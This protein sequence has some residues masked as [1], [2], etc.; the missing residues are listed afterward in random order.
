MERSELNIIFYDT[1]TTGLRP[2]KDRIIEIAAYNSRTEESFVQF[3][4]PGIPIPAESIAIS[5][6]TDAMVAEAGSFAEV[7]AQFIQFCGEEA[8]LIA[9]NNDAFDQPFIEQEARLSGLTLPSWRYI[10]SLKWAR[11][12]RPDLPKHSLQA[13]RELFGIPANQ[14]HRALDDVKV[15]HEMFSMLTDDLSAQ[16]IL[17]LMNAAPRGIVRMP[18]GK[19][20]GKPLTEVP[21]D[22]VQWLE[23]NGAFD[24]SENL[25]LKEAFRKVGVLA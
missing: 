23:K 15:L 25:S 1:E 3:V 22:Y 2:G 9:H 14:A 13:L 10:D 17:E 11:K 24:K 5:G 21:K 19:H 16:Q 7:G 8:V 4:N 20:Q 6:I 18:F 12:F